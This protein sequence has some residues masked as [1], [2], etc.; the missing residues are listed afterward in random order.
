[1]ETFQ[2]HLEGASVPLVLHDVQTA[3]HA[4]A[5]HKHHDTAD[6]ASRAVLLVLKVRRKHQNHRQGCSA[7][8]IQEPDHEAFHDELRARLGVEEVNHTGTRI[9]VVPSIRDEM[10]NIS[11]EFSEI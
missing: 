1:L 8:Q 7:A 5:E 10:R 6:D 9:R 11:I 2:P 3:H 4:E